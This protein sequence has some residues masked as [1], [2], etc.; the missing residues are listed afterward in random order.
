MNAAAVD[1][2]QTTFRILDAEQNGAFAHGSCDSWC[3]RN[4]P[5]L[6][7]LHI[8]INALEW[9]LLEMNVSMVSTITS[10]KLTSYDKTFHDVRITLRTYARYDAGQTAGQETQ[11][12]SNW[13]SQHFIAIWLFHSL[14]F[15]NENSNSKSARSLD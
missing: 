9:T 15:V 4:C 7:S 11:A 5:C 12:G 8:G 10:N 1:K 6:N 2:L 3:W 14:G 13:Y